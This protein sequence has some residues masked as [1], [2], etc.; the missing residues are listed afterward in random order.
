MAVSV[1]MVVTAARLQGV[2][3]TSGLKKKKKAER[4]RRDQLKRIFALGWRKCKHIY[5]ETL[6][7]ER[8]RIQTMCMPRG[9]P[10]SDPG[11][12]WEGLEDHRC[13]ERQ[14]HGKCKET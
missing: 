11:G 13:T 7:G 1:G 4:E 3:M 8:L 14:S 10:P 9:L 5:K 6:G 2:N 12:M